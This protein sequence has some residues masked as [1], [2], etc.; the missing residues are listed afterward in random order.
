MPVLE[1]GEGETNG[2]V[3]VDVSLSVPGASQSF[4]ANARPIDSAAAQGAGLDGVERVIQVGGGI[5]S[6]SET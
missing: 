1:A 5:R 2:V 3:S 6:L 4:R